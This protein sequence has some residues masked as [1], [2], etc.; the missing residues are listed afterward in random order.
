MH[1]GIEA[2]Y[3]EEAERRLIEVGVVRRM[4][5]S[6]SVVALRG[7]SVSCVAGAGERCE[8]LAEVGIAPSDKDMQAASAADLIAV[9]SDELLRIVDLLVC[10]CVRVGM[11][12]RR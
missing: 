4:L 10:V 6:A 9:C 12:V 5:G 8:K 7:Q 3:W 2:R 11:C 1:M